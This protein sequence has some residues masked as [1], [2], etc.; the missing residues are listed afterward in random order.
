MKKFFALA[1]M[2][3]MT[4]LGMNAQYRGTHRVSSPGYQRVLPSRRFGYAG[5]YDTTYRPYLGLRI[6]P[7]FSG[8]GGDNNSDVKT[9]VNVGM[10][11]GLPLSTYLPMSLETGLYYTEKGGKNN[12]T[13]AK[14]DY[15]EVPLVF[16]YHAYVGGR[17]TVQPYIGGFASL[18]VGGKIK[19]KADLVAYSSFGDRASQYR[20]GDAGIKLGCGMAFDM[21]YVDLNYDWGLANISHSDYFDAH[22]N[23]VTLNVGVNF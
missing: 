4:A 6:G 3:F 14:L 19:D 16:K 10:A 21:F 9:G 18:G 8:V 15:L 1:V 23:C 7:T 11:V 17:C 5:Y 22:T 2:G 12:V 20:R 13:S